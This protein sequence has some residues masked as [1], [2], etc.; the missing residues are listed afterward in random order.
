MKFHHISNE[1]NIRFF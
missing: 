1:V